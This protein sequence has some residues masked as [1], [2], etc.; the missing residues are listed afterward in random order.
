MADCS[1]AQCHL[2]CGHGCLFFRNDS[3]CRLSAVAE[4]GVWLPRVPSTRRCRPGLDGQMLCISCPQDPDGWRDER[5]NGAAV[6]VSGNCYHSEASDAGEVIWQLPI[7][8]SASLSGPATVSGPC[9]LVLA[10]AGSSI[11]NVR[12]RCTSGDAAVHIIGPRVTLRGSVIDAALARAV[13]LTGVDVTGLKVTS[14]EPI[15]HPVAVLG[16]TKGGFTIDC[17]PGGQVVSQPLSGKGTYS[18]SCVVVDL[19][20]L[21]NV[22]GTHY[23]IEFYNKNA[24]S[25]GDGGWL[26]PLA[27]TAALGLL[28]LLTAHQDVVALVLARRSQ[29]NGPQ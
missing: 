20:Q 8:L 18:P 14:L 13:S 23:E 4:T 2:C 10:R 29:P 22:F 3:G 5:S 26:G 16:N 11:E 9:P 1:P 24:F 19:Q 21:L 15:D 12:F 7:N 25:T 27:G 17:G 28:L 6:V